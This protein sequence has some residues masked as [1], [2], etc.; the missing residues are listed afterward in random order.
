MTWSV[1]PYGRLKEMV[2]RQICS[3]YFKQVRGRTSDIYFP[4]NATVSTLKL[5]RPINKWLYCL[6]IRISADTDC[7]TFTTKEQKYLLFVGGS[8]P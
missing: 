5:T 3:L 4:S 6:A 7:N 8:I 1:D 2:T